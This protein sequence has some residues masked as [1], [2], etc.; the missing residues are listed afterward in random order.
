MNIDRDKY[1]DMINSINLE[2]IALLNCESK[3]H[4][5]DS[6][7]NLSVN[8][9]F[10]VNKVRME[11]NKLEA[12]AEFEVSTTEPDFDEIVFEVNFNYILEYSLSSEDNLNDIED[13]YIETFLKHNLP[14]NIWPYAR[15]FVSS[16]TTRMGYPPL[17]IPMHKNKD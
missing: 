5:E 1:N 2:K 4:D 10:S 3:I 7:G 13:E 11:K 12:I 8:V 14:I 17:F 9:N 16:M 6:F 15:E